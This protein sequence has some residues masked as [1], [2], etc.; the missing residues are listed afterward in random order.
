MV[1][2]SN[3]PL[4]E[5]SVFVT[6]LHFLPGERLGSLTAL[7]PPP[8]SPALSGPSTALGM[9]KAAPSSPQKQQHQSQQVLLTSLNHVFPST[10]FSLCSPQGLDAAF[11]IDDPSGTVFI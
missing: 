2:W 9:G 5:V 8:A 3:K 1:V 4:S 7:L 6:N 11:M 10:C